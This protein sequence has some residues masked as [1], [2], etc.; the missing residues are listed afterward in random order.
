MVE[1]GISARRADLSGVTM[2]EQTVL[3]FTCII[4]SDLL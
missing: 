2:V 4:Q 1:D 3:D